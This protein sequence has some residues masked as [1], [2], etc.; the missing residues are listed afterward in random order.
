MLAN[1]AA[2]STIRVRVR[3]TA[4]SPL[5]GETIE[6][7]SSGSNNTIVHLGPTD[8]TGMAVGTLASTTVEVKTLTI[9]VDPSAS[10]VV[11]DQQPT[12]EFVTPPPTNVILILVDDVGT[13]FLSSTYDFNMFT[14]TSESWL[15]GDREISCFAFDMNDLRLVEPIKYSGK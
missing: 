10:A 5:A 11:L 2:I 4:G 9:T 13:D 15:E 1:G 14:P 7:A 6:I 8:A 3:D 12:V